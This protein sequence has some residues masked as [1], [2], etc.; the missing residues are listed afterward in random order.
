MDSVRTQTKNTC[1]FSQNTNKNHL[2][3]QSEHKQKSPRRKVVPQCCAHPMEQAAKHCTIH[4][5]LRFRRQLKFYLFST[6]LSPTSLLIPLTGS[7]FPQYLLHPSP[8]SYLPSLLT[9]SLSLPQPPPP[10][11]SRIIVYVYVRARE[12]LFVCVYVCLCV[13]VC[14]SV[15]VC[16]CLCV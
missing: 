13:C 4:K 3:I 8:Y 2:W 16:V 12:S 7:L 11:T 14:V 6:L 10:P 5:T 15:S 9:L 1:G